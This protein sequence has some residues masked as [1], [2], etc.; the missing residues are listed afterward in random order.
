[1]SD[2]PFLPLWISKYNNGTKHLNL[3]EDGAYMRLLRLCWET[4]G[5]TMPAD[6]TWVR[7]H[8]RVS[9]DDFDRV[10]KPI[11]QEFFKVLRG[12]Y[13]NEKLSEVYGEVF[14]KTKRRKTA[15]K[16]GASARWQKD[17]ENPSSNRMPDASQKEPNRNSKPEPKPEPE[18]EASKLAARSA[19]RAS[20]RK[21]VGPGVVDGFVDGITDRTLDS[22]MDKFDL[23]T[24]VLPVLRERTAGE[25]VEP[26]RLIGALRAEFEARRDAPPP[27]PT[28]KPKPLEI[29]EGQ[30]GDVV[31][32]IIAAKGEASA[33]N[34]LGGAVWNG[35]EVYA[36]T[37]FQRDQIA[38]RFGGILK[39]H[40][41]AVALA[42]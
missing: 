10:V 34:W 19:A 29:P 28:A 27:P 35:S 42:Q 13:E 23:E 2:L 25:R 5:G 18:P 22:L 21:A 33:A 12:R 38:Q 3:E 7:R 8:M 17:K 9:Q 26:L 40:G 41:Y 20:I 37:E 24:V 39:Q 14:A 36:E 30:A 6:D 1:M 16:T 4:P 11:L 31:R 15:A 32:A